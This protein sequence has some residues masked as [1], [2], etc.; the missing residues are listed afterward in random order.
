MTQ[1][2]A[3]IST[4]LA[5]PTGRL[6]VGASPGAAACRVRRHYQGGSRV[7]LVRTRT[8]CRSRCARVPT[9]RPAGRRKPIRRWRARSSASA[10]NFDRP[11]LAFDLRGSSRNLNIARQAHDADM[12]LR[13]VWT[14]L[15]SDWRLYKQSDRYRSP[16]PDLSSP[17]MRS[18]FKSRTSISVFLDAGLPGLHHECLD[19]SRCRDVP[20]P[21]SCPVRLTLRP[22]G[23]LSA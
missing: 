20:H 5:R 21:T 12:N 13:S 14:F 7:V 2:V 15:K 1:A 17:S 10:S 19:R 9:L 8:V 6:I 11:T 4:L 18:T 16:L 22:M 23:N 3:V